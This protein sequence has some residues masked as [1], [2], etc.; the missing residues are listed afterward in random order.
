[1]CALLVH[2]ADIK[3]VCVCVCVCVGVCVRSPL[4][5]LFA[6]DQ[7]GT[8]IHCYRPLHRLESRSHSACVF[9]SAMSGHTHTCCR[10]GHMIS[11]L[12]DGW[13]GDPWICATNSGDVLVCVSGGMGRIVHPPLS[14]HS[15]TH[16]CSSIHPLPALYFVCGWMD[17]WFACVVWRFILVFSLWC[18]ERVGGGVM[19]ER[20]IGNE[21]T[22]RTIQC[23]AASHT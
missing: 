3:C 16:V 22:L 23:N 19:R 15:N 2:R 7:L 20:S 21:E 9:S 12:M 10:H 13:M 1:M 6:V 5:R 11:E 14:T 4:R 18:H 8:S 17:G